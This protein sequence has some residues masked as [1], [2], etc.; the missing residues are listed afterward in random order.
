MHVTVLDNTNCI[1]A[2]VGATKL[3]EW[4]PREPYSI[5]IQSFFSLNYLIF[6]YF[7]EEVSIFL[8]FF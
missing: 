1:S 7:S 6:N 3:G 8:H 4:Q 2:T 5:F